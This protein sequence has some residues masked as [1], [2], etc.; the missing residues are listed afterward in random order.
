MKTLVFAISLT[1]T[2]AAASS[3]DVTVSGKGQAMILIPGLSSSGDVWKETVARYQSHFECHVLTLAG[4]AG[5]PPLEG[6]FLGRVRDD[7]A[8][9]I[10]EKNLVKPVIVGHSL[11]GFLAL[12]FASKYPDVPG[13]VVIVDAYP[14]LPAV[15]SPNITAAEAAGYAKN[16][17]NSMGSQTQQQYEEYVKSGASTKMMVGNDQQLA[18]V[19]EWGLKSDRKAVMEALAEMMTVDPRDSIAAIKCP[20]LV[21]GSWIG[22]K[23]YTDHDKTLAS[24]RTQY[25]KLKGVQI[26]LTDRGHHFM[27]WDDADWMYAQMDRFLGQ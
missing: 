22:Y 14:F 2:V 10:K 8:A 19:V 1:V 9:Y 27:M 7:L 21:L 11:G 26:E 15:W 24:L 12:D 6:P 5:V 25:A 20:T 23:Q 3:F 13:K 16:V 18:T 17:R 4:F